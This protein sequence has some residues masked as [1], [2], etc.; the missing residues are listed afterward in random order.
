MDDFIGDTFLFNAT[1]KEI[2]DAITLAYSDLQYSSQVFELRNR[3]RDLTQGNQTVTQYF[4]SLKK[5]WKELNL[6]NNLAWKDPDDGIMYNRMLARDRVSDFLAGLNIVLD[7]VR[8]RLSG[9]K[10]VPSIDE[11]FTEVRRKESRKRVM[12]GHNRDLVTL[13]ID[14]SAMAS[15][16]D[17]RSTK[18]GV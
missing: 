15:K 14:S 8:G 9:L 13:G 2:W 6:F 4:N 12:L 3:T 11:A 10:P 17:S 16:T 18:K 7:E 5:L 1:A